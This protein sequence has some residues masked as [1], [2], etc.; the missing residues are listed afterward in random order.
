M[1][2]P[3][4]SHEDEWDKYS[5]RPKLAGAT[6]EAHATALHKWSKARRQY[7]LVAHDAVT[8]SFWAVLERAGYPRDVFGA[9]PLPEFDVPARLR[10]QWSSWS[11]N[12]R[13]SISRR[14]SGMQQSVKHKL[15]LYL[16]T[17]E[18]SEVTISENT[19]AHLEDGGRLT[20]N[21][22]TRI[23]DETTATAEDRFEQT[24]RNGL[25]KAFIDFGLLTSDLDT[26]P[27]PPEPEEPATEEQTADDLRDKPLRS[28]SNLAREP[29]ICC[30]R[31]ITDDGKVIELHA[32]T[33]MKL[34]AGA[35][36]EAIAE[37]T[38]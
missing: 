26:P 35:V 18:T 38:G 19:I 24:K 28:V 29:G 23:V 6:K 12:Y 15:H 4:I 3:A 1:A 14:F 9:K 7:E 36:L 21:A 16:S 10:S 37:I 30:V 32:G 5:P 31:V 20:R 11:H 25:L 27:P 34:T 17:R 8:W 13:Y 22:D 2:R 33:A